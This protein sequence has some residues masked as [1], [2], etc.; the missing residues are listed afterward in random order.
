MDVGLRLGW[1]LCVRHECHCGSRVDVHGI[2][3]FVCKRSPGRTSRHH[4]FNDLIARTFSS[5]GIPVTK[6]PSGLFRSDGKQPDGLT[7]IPWSNGKALG[8]KNNKSAQSNLGRGPRRCE[9][10]S[11][12][13]TMARP[14]FA[15]KSTP[16]RGLIPK[17]HYVPHP[18]RPGPV[19]ADARIRSAVFTA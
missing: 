15:P 8:S 6:E 3:S 16:S 9:S 17:H 11:P 12:L 2:H 5:A 19:Q 14:K 13:V 1:D 10:K 4:A 18:W 7:L